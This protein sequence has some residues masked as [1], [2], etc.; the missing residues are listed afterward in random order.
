M[1]Y[2]LGGLPAVG[3]TRVSMGVLKGPGAKRSEGRRGE[4]NGAASEQCPPTPA[5]FLPGPAA[6]PQP[7]AGRGK[8]KVTAPRSA[9]GGTPGLGREPGG[10]EG[11]RQ[12]ARRPPPGPGRTRRPS[13]D[14]STGPSYLRALGDRAAGGSAAARSPLTGPCGGGGARGA[15]SM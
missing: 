12:G 6:L 5:R 13:C 10:K 2:P 7:L 11:G 15:V 8:G 1:T 3:R 9:A 4:G 14:W